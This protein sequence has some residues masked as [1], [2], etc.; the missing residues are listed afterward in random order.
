MRERR[1]GKYIVSIVL[2]LAMVIGV[3][4]FTLPTSVSAIDPS[5]SLAGLGTEEDPY[6]IGS[7]AD[8]LKFAN[9]VN[10]NAGADSGYF[11][12]TAD[13]TFNEGD[14]SDWGTTPPAMNLADY[15]GVNYV[16]GNIAGKDAGG[17]PF[18]GTFDGNGHIISGVYISKTD[19]SCGLFGSTAA[20]Y[21][22]TIKNVVIT[23]SYYNSPGGEVGALVGQTSGGTTT[24]ENTL[25]TESVYIKSGAGA[26]GGFIGHNGGNGYTGGDY[27]AYQSIAITNSACGA[28]VDS[29]SQNV[30]GFVGNG[31][32]GATTFA[33]CVFYGW[34]YGSN[35]IGGILGINANGSS[36]PLTFNDC[37]VIY[38]PQKCANPEATC[39]LYHIQGNTTTKSTASQ[40]PT[41]NYCVSQASAS[42]KLARKVRSGSTGNYYG[43]GDE[44]QDA[45]ANA[46]VLAGFL[47]TDAGQALN[48]DGNWTEIAGQTFNWGKVHLTVNTGLCLPTA[49]FNAIKANGNMRDIFESSAY[50][51]CTVVVDG[52]TP[53]WLLTAWNNGTI[54]INTVEKYIEFVKFFNGGYYNEECTGAMAGKTVNLTANLTFNTGDASTWGDTAP[55]NDMTEFIIGSTANPFK[56]TFNGNG[57]TISGFY[58][59]KTGEDTVSIFGS[60]AGGN[61]ANIHDLIVTNSYF[62]GPGCVA[63]IVGQTSGGSTQISNIYVTDSVYIVSSESYAGGIVGHIGQNGYSFVAN[64][65]AVII[66]SCVNAGTITGSSTSVGGILGNAN[67]KQV[68]V[69][70]CLNMGSVTGTNNVGGIIGFAAGGTNIAEVVNYCVNTGKITATVSSSN[71]YEN[72]CAITGFTS[73]SLKTATGCYYIAGTADYGLVK[74][75]TEL[76]NAATAVAGADV[77]ST[78][79]SANLP[80]GLEA[81][82][83][84]A[85]GSGNTYEI[86]I[87]SAFEPYALPNSEHYLQSNAPTWL[88]SHKY[89]STLD[90]GTVAQYKEFATFV[91]G[92]YTHTQSHDFDGKTVRLTAD[93]NF[94]NEDITG[95]IVA[96]ASS[97]PFRGTFDGQ[98][99]TISGVRM[100][101]ADGDGDTVGLFGFTA[102]G[103]TAT[104]KNLLVTN[105]T[106]E[107]GDG[108]VGSIIAQTAGGV[109]NIINIYITDSV[110]ITSGDAYA[111]GLIGHNGG[112]GYGNPKIVAES[113]VNAATVTAEGF[114][115]VGGIVG[116]GNG[117]SIEIYNC[118]NL[119]EIT[120]NRYVGGILG[121]GKANEGVIVTVSGC[122]NVGQVTSEYTTLT[123]EGAACAIADFGVTAR[124]SITSANCYYVRGTGLRGT[125]ESN[126]YI[127]ENATAVSFMA[128]ADATLPEGL[129]GEKWTA[130]GVEGE[131]KTLEVCIP[132]GVASFAPA[133]TSF[134]T[135][136]DVPTW[137][138]AYADTASFTIT[139]VTQWQQIANY[140]NGAYVENGDFENKTVLLGNNLTFSGDST[141]Y[142]I[143]SM[144]HPF[145]GTFNGQGYTISGFRVVKNDAD[146]AGLFGS[147]AGGKIATIQNLVITNSHFEAAGAVG[148]LIGQTSGG[149]TIVENVYVTA[150]VEI[151]STDNYVGGIVGHVGQNGYQFITDEPALSVNACVNAATVTAE[152]SNNVGGILGNENGKRV[153]VT[154]CLNVGT[155]TGNS[156]TSGIIGRIETDTVI[157]N[158]VNAGQ[159]NGSTEKQAD[160]ATGNVTSGRE[161]T[162]SN[163]Y[164]IYNPFYNE[165]SNGTEGTVNLSGNT[166][167][168]EIEGKN[169]GWSGWSQVSGGIPVPTSLSSKV[170]TLKLYFKFKLLNGAS[171][172]VGDPSGIRFTAQFSKSYIDGLG[173]SM[174]ELGIIVMPKTYLDNIEEF[175]VD[176]IEEF[177]TTLG[178]K[179]AY[180]VID[181][182]GE[183]FRYANASTAATDGYYTFNGV[184]A[185]VKEAN[186]TRDFCAIA[187]VKLTDGTI[188]YSDYSGGRN[189]RNIAEV[190]EKAYN[191]TVTLETNA[192]ITGYMNFVEAIVENEGTD[193]EVTKYVY[194]PYTASQRETLYNFFHKDQD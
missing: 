138:R 70:N 45:I 100:F 73:K 97:D 66:D 147:T 116:N 132:V 170:G 65:P 156:F 177:E 146:T 134:H 119:G 6:Q 56:G 110:T 178:G 71:A 108:A 163:C 150:S 164:Y 185:N 106:F 19:G 123:N 17:N 14:A 152:Q 10:D 38:K 141:A 41:I 102:G 89:I 112:N 94:N 109:T 103:K 76:A 191:D 57:Y 144:L 24:I 176:A 62:E 135:T 29:T 23:N 139:T 162:I 111:G 114:N 78:L 28:T 15:G 34:V 127:D 72:A 172:R 151:V 36:R 174:E 154:N 64:T 22:A 120:G 157:T 167:Y 140:V 2:T 7:V 125:Y 105:S 159:V 77:L 80:S 31:N 3:A 173:S 43:F 11:Q 4:M 67:N 26:S 12:L 165:K 39:Y 153:N 148:A 82:N 186:Y 143:G 27:A 30:G 5:A 115:N 37:M 33:D 61:T 175:T 194:S 149:K 145:A 188:V 155:I 182:L 131:P 9:M 16:V 86:C 91:N 55:S 18:R 126:S 180:V 137:L 20:G 104:I 190:A 179:R 183:G 48:H 117:Q 46:A 75:S 84:V 68:T 1:L 122:V 44:D 93:L 189:C 88:R 187:F 158:C 98:G 90:I 49:L 51:T 58:A 63:S 60:T 128:V 166:P 54:N 87:P 169:L 69:T 113:C 47:S 124:T 101:K 50:F 160:I 83:W 52:A 13:I 99:H 142:M 193:D 95:Y 85:R 184:L 92:G 8:W 21:S 168:I 42:G 79:L 81:G 40:Q 136:Y 74:G 130:R 53:S 35:S 171:V 129:D 59:K 133:T 118:L 107:S 192:G 161:V 25:V 181:N 121:R 96:S 32:G